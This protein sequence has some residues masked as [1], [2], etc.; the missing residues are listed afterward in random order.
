MELL[1]VAELRELPLEEE[2]LPHR[3]GMVVLHV[4]VPHVQVAPTRSGVEMSPLFQNHIYISIEG[5]QR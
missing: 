4:P 2:L 5:G 3:G 1:E